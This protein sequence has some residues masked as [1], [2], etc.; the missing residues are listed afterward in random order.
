MNYLVFVIRRNVYKVYRTVL[1]CSQV[2]DVGFLKPM[3]R[4][5]NQGGG[6]TRH[7]LIIVDEPNVYEESQIILVSIFTGDE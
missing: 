4:Y 1:V 3:C 2:Q 7:G 5:E 6:H